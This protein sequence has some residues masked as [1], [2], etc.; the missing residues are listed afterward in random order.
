MPSILVMS[1]KQAGISDFNCISAQNHTP[2]ALT[3]QL[4]I[5]IAALW[6]HR[7][8]F[9]RSVDLFGLPRSYNRYRC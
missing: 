2:A 7:G 9:G 6:S 4:Q 3:N 1:A 5:D 8:S